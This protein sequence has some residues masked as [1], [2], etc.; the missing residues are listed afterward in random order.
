MAQEEIY[1]TRD[2]SYSAWHRRKS[3]A[4]FVGIE[5]A[6]TLALIDLD[7]SLWVECSD[8]DYEPLALIETA[9]DRGQIF[10]SATLVRNLS[11]RTK[12]IV[13]AYCLLYTL[14]NDLNPGADFAVQ[15]IT[16][17][18]VKRIFPVPES[19]WRTLSPQ[20]WAEALVKIREWSAERLDGMLFGDAA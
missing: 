17:F 1:N 9:V 3:T 19:H 4:R 8:G 14:S 6:Q 7:A 16:S 18:R 5:R 12:P 15:D 20:E 11:R 2:R 10:K 13:P